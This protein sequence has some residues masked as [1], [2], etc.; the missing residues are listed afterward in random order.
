MRGLLSILEDRESVGNSVLPLASVACDANHLRRVEI[1]VAL[2]AAR[3]RTASTPCASHEAITGFVRS[4]EHYRH[5][6]GDCPKKAHQFTGDRG[7]S[8]NRTES[9]R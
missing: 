4:A 6:P 9:F 5:A 1:P 2:L 3:D 7:L 8:R